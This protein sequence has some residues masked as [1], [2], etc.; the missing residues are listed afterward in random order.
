MPGQFRCNPIYLSS[1]WVTDPNRATC[2]NY[3]RSRSKVIKHL[4]EKRK[5]QIAAFRPDKKRCGLCID[6]DR[7]HCFNVDNEAAFTDHNK[8][9]CKDF[10][11]DFKKVFK[12]AKRKEKY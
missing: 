12:Y 11:R 10:K 6:Y 8:K 1:Y 7:Y 9:G 4:K 3:E 5:R 2:N